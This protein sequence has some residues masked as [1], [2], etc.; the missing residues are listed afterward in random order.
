MFVRCDL[1]AE[2][3]KEMAE[4]A[5]SRTADDMLTY[6]DESIRDGYTLSVKEAEQGYQASLTQAKKAA[7]GIP[8]VGKCLVTRASTPERALWSLYH[9]H[10]NVLEKDWSRGNE[11]ALLDW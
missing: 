4:W 10:I 9:K 5:N 8:N 3:K 6:L 7:V 11:E 1:S 2:Q